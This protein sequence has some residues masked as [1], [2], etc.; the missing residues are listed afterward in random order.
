MADFE[1]EGKPKKIELPPNT[2]KDPEDQEALTRSFIRKRTFFGERIG[3]EFVV[4]KSS[5]NLVVDIGEDFETFSKAN[6]E[7]DANSFERFID[8]LS[9]DFGISRDDLEQNQELREAF[10]ELR[11]IELD[12]S[13]RH[14]AR[15]RYFELKQKISLILAGY[16]GENPEPVKRFYDSYTKLEKD[17]Y[18]TGRIFSLAK[19][20]DPKLLKMVEGWRTERRKLDEEYEKGE[21]SEEDYLVK[22]DVINEKAVKESGDKSLQDAWSVF[23]Q[24]EA[25][26]DAQEVIPDDSN[27]KSVTDKEEAQTALAEIA[28]Q[29]LPLNFHDNGSASLVLGDEKFP[30]DVFVFKNDKT[31]QFV[32]YIV[33]AYSDDGIVK[34]DSAT[35]LMD[36]LDQRYI[37]AYLSSKIGEIPG[38]IDSP[39]DIPDQYLVGLCEKLIGKG[40]KRGYKIGSEDK[41]VLDALVPV[42]MMKD[43]KYSGFYNRIRVLDESIATEEDAGFIRKRLLAGDVNSLQDLL[44]ESV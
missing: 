18:I 40:H 24:D 27:E 31:S 32:Y 2:V 20:R 28:S 44:G 34:V 15:Q 26:A 35:D 5:L 9:D 42:L 14:T 38:E 23:N 10:L 36:A 12:T 8:G 30:I 1:K 33:D 39:S 37:D 16:V 43:E 29:G 13:K 7:L 41:A 22:R 4:K 25:Y 21:I 19:S 17:R 3:N 6:D 11:E